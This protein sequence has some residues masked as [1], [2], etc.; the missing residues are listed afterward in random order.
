MYSK[1]LGSIALIAGLLLGCTQV[2][3]HHG[4]ASSYDNSK[5]FT[6]EATI[7]EFHYANPHPQLYFDVKD[8]NG[9]VVHWSGEIGPNPAMLVQDGWG[10]R[11]SEQAL[12]PGTVVTLTLSPSR[13]GSNVAL[14]QKIVN[15]KGET[16]LGSVQLG[17]LPPGRGQGK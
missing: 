8:A 9:K 4:T 2:F 14:V 5:S 17:N 13:S 11:R 3:A 1:L 16:V 7:T 6:V 12:M 10:R 15:S